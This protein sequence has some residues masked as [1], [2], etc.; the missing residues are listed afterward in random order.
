ME[1]FDIGIKPMRLGLAVYNAS[2]EK[3]LEKE[4]ETRAVVSKFEEDNSG[5]EY[6]GIIILR[7]NRNGGAKDPVALVKRYVKDNPKGLVLFIAGVSD[8]EAKD[9]IRHMEKMA[10]RVF[11]VD[12]PLGTIGEKEFRK[13]ISEML[14]EWEICNTNVYHVFGAKGGCGTT[15]IT[16]SLAN[17]LS[18]KGSVAVVEARPSLKHHPLKEGI[19]VFT[20]DALYTQ[21]LREMQITHHFVILDGIS[22]ADNDQKNYCKQIL[23]MDSSPESMERAKAL[24]ADHVVLTHFCSGVLPKE[25]VEKEIGKSITLVIDDDR[26]K[27]LT[28]LAT[29]ESVI[30]SIE[31]LE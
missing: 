8:D 26:P 30:S 7:K 9:I 16:A 6:D 2:F 3:W 15:T 11:V 19:K 20:K 13:G 27:F 5:D 17:Y 29:G 4:L 25:V 12:S 22:P 21:D 31:K 24:T 28:A 23:V 14:L 10:T 18:T 1:F